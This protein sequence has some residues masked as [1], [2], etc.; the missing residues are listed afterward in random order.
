MIPF[1]DSRNAN[2][3]WLTSKN[4]S[5]SVT[6][7]VSAVLSK[8]SSKTMGE[9]FDAINNWQWCK[10]DFQ[11]LYIVEL[12]VSMRQTKSTKW[13]SFVTVTHYKILH[14]WLI[15]LIKCGLDVQHC[16][17]SHKTSSLSSNLLCF[18]IF[19]I[20]CD[21]HILLSCLPVVI[22]VLFCAWHFHLDITHLSVNN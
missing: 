9:S 10:C 15:K 3:R 18:F 19:C 12:S 13:I 1:P 17:I 14:L 21:V 5:L 4:A 22:Y 20:V 11:W 16:A 7:V 2:Y 6:H 8:N